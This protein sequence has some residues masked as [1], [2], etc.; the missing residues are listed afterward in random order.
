MTALVLIRTF[1]SIV[2][3]LIL[4]ACTSPSLVAGHLAACLFQEATSVEASVCV[5][6]S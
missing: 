4:Q 2:A 3:H 1:I 6:F 5:I